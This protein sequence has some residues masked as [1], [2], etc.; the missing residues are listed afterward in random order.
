MTLTDPAE[1][2]AADRALEILF[3]RASIEELERLARRYFSPSA[4]TRR[5]LAERN[6]LIR[7][8]ATEI[9]A[10]GGEASGRGLGDSIATELGRY[11]ASGW[12]VERG[13]TPPADPH[14]A[15]LHRIRTVRLTS[16]QRRDEAETA[17]WRTVRRRLQHGYKN[18]TNNPARDGAEPDNLGAGCRRVISSG[19]N[20]LAQTSSKIVRSG[21]LFAQ[22]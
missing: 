17:E 1:I 7:H 22:R 14:R 15:L 10:G 21:D 3:A 20:R 13:R 11:A 18:V 2:D 16:Y 8:L 12:R 6:A 4:L 5:R 19:S 9:L